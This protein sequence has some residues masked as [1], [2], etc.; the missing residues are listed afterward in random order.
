MVASSSDVH[1][2]SRPL[3]ACWLTTAVWHAGHGLCFV[4]P[5][6]KI[7]II[8]T[9][10]LTFLQQRRHR[11]C[12]L[13]YKRRAWCCVTYHM[14]C[15]TTHIMFL[16]HHACLL[17]Y[18]QHAWC[19]AWCITRC[20]VAYHVAITYH[21]STVLWQNALAASRRDQCS[22]HQPKLTPNLFAPPP[23]PPCLP[24]LLLHDSITLNVLSS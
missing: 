9:T 12:P 18:K 15:C 21:A 19:C 24:A 7:V 1:S 13:W 8:C 6:G 14:F 17:R 16:Q 22:R 3:D 10:F 2:R 20:V 4:L 23:P 5:L 11:A